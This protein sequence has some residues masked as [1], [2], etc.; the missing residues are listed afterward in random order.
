LRWAEVVS[1]HDAG[2]GGVVDFALS[3]LLQPPDPGRPRLRAKGAT[4]TMSNLARLLIDE[5]D[6]LLT[7]SE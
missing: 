6:Q 2:Y 5:I 3:D 1:F 7:P 4:M